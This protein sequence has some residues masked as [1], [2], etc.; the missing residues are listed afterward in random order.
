MKKPRSESSLQFTDP[1]EGIT[2][3]KARNPLVLAADSMTGGSP[4]EADNVTVASHRDM[5]GTSD[6]MRVS[7]KRHER[8]ERFSAIFGQTTAGIAQTD[9]TGRFVLVNQRY[10][11]IVGRSAEE[12]YELRM[13][14]ITH[15]DY[16]S[17]NLNQFKR[18][19]AEGQK[20]TVEKR[21]V[22]PDGSCVWVHNSVSLIRDREDNPSY[23]VAFTL[24]ITRQKQIEH[25]RERLLDRERATRCELTEIDRRKDE[26]L[27]ILGHELRNPLSGIVS[28]MQ[29]LEQLS[30]HDSVAMEMHGVIKRQSLHMTKLIDDLLDISRIACGKILLQMVRLDLVTLV[31]NAVADHQHYLDTNQLT[32]SSELPDAPIWVIGD[33]TRLSQVITNLLHNAT[34]FTDPGGTIGVYVNRMGT[35]AALIVTDNGIGIQSMD[36]AAIFEPFRQAESSRVRNGGGLGLGLALS[37]QLI[38]K[39]GGSITAASDGLR[40]GSVFSIRLPLDRELMP[41]SSQPVTQVAATPTP[42]RI[43]IVDDR[44]DERLTLTVLFTRMGQ[45]VAQA[46]NGAAALD[47]ARTFH[48]E[49]VFCDIGLPDMD[50]YAVARAMRADPALDGATLVALTGYGQPE[51]RDR[52]FKAGFDRHLTKPISYD[53]LANLLLEIHGPW[54]SNEH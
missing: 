30:C 19:V 15:P 27:A 50:G 14:D 29:V 33:A 5:H 4:G 36:L 26:F 18:L 44:R 22:R 23:A 51:D 32:L 42:H 10:C 40:F 47:A 1:I 7:E 54:K 41:E 3:P 34:K 16:R 21:Y 46:E 11:E 2:A 53:Q 25:E 43:L 52:A 8:D 35:S 31:R 24:D 6:G 37:K 20:F 38:E 48:P 12:L 13:Q 17:D 28:A 49:I 45:Q 9:L 39:H